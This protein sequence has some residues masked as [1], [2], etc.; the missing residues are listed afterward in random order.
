MVQLPAVKEAMLLHEID[1]IDA[2]MYQYEQ[3]EKTL[4]PGEM[5]DRIFSLGVKV[6]KPAA[7][8]EEKANV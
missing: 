7:N 3:A 4:N 5:S 8:A 1:V 6:Y 2:S